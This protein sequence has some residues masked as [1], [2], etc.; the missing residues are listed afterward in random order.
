M[1]CRTGESTAETNGKSGEIRMWIRREMVWG[2]DVITL[3]WTRGRLAQQLCFWTNPGIKLP[4]AMCKF[5]STTP[6][7]GGLNMIP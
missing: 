5:T 2:R 1:A 4:E 7:M 3:G 6:K